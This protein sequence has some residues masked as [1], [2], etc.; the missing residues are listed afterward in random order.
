MNKKGLRSTLNIR[1]TFQMPPV[2]PQMAQF[3]S[4]SHF[5]IQKCPTFFIRVYYGC[6]ASLFNPYGGAHPLPRKFLNS[7]N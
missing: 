6:A 7:Y 5:E 3:I 4:I 1:P 2:I